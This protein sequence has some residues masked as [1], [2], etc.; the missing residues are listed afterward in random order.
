MR[1]TA[2]LLLVAACG[3]SRAPT[4]FT[5]GGPEVPAEIGMTYRW[6]FEGD[7]VGA[8]PGALIVALGQWVVVD[9]AGGRV[10]RQTAAFGSPDFP[11]AVIESLT[12]SN[13]TARVRCRP[14]TGETD[15]ACGL[16]FRFQDSEN[17]YLT[18]ANA[19]EGNVNVYRV[20]DGDRQQLKGASATVTAGAWHTL[21]AHANGAAL[22]VS[23]DGQIVVQVA[24]TTFSK[25]KIGLWTKADSVTSFDDL[26]ATAE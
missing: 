24:D 11:R 9:D 8:T 18:R 15:Q 21:E 16:M 26:E 4:M 14:E 13:L 3:E 20:V 1:R 6:S 25:G 10:L 22:E 12:F 7:P 19:L 23:W 17:Y 2:L 5:N